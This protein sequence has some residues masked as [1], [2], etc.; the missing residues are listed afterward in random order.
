[1]SDKYKAEI[2]LQYV[3]H[4]SKNLYKFRCVKNTVKKCLDTVS[5][6]RKHLCQEKLENMSSASIC[7]ALK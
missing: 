5:N 7:L 3:T 4:H 1:M 2:G 6:H